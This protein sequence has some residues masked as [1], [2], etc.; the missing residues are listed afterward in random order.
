[1]PES[2]LTLTV[3]GSPSRWPWWIHRCWGSTCRRTTS[4][5]C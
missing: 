2:T 4:S 5:G 3:D 1:M